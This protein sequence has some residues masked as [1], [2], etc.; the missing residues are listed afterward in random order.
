MH[1]AVPHNGHH[2]ELRPLPARGPPSSCSLRVAPKKTGENWAR[3]SKHAIRWLCERHDRG[4]AACS[5]EKRRSL[6]A[7][8]PVTGTQSRWRVI[9]EYRAGRS[10]YQFVFMAE[11]CPRSSRQFKVASSSHCVGLIQNKV[12]SWC[13]RFTSSSCSEST[14]LLRTFL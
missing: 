14:L 4:G 9:T 11:P 3:L 2:Q 13:S 12:A 5:G 6:A 8:L 1:S 10:V 7:S